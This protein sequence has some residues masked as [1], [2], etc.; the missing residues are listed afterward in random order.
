MG[1]MLQ[2]QQV[3]VESFGTVLE[4][5]LVVIKIYQISGTEAL[6]TPVL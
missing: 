5:M 1:Q 6:S 3:N 4:L 2:I